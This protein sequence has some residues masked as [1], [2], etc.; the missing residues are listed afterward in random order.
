MPKVWKNSTYWIVRRNNRGGPPCYYIDTLKRRR[1]D[2][3]SAAVEWVQ[4]CPWFGKTWEEMK[5]RNFE[6]VKVNLDIGVNDTAYWLRNEKLKRT[7]D[8]N[9]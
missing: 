5:Q 2:S 6:C 1:D 9:P 3:I 7:K 8:H 4:V